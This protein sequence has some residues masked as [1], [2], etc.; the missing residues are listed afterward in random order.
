MMPAARRV[1]GVVA[2]FAAGIGIANAGRVVHESLASVAV[3]AQRIVVAEVVAVD[4]YDE[5]AE[6]ILD[7]EA[8]PEQLISGP[9]FEVRDEDTLLCRYREAR[10]Q[11]RGDAVLSP[12]VSG[13]GEEFRTRR[14]DRVILLLAAQ[15]ENA[16][17]GPVPPQS[18]TD[19][20][21]HDDAMLDTE[22]DAQARQPDCTLLRIESL[23]NRI[24]ILRYLRH[25]AEARGNP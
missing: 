1:I 9:G 6:R 16:A 14:G 8:M 7:V 5:G 3:R 24:A 11:R 10:V 4:D 23:Q 19:A 25:A 17:Q 18:E 15:P 2:V 20:A 22:T 13:S 21:P 12:L